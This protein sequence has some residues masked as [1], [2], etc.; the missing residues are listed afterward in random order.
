MMESGMMT[1]RL[2][3]LALNELS[4]VKDLVSLECIPSAFQDEFDRFFFGK[5]LVRKGEK[6]FAYP[7]D[8]R[9]WV[10]FVFMRYKG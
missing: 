1:D 6:L 4:N 2:N 5:T 9:R 3:L 8:I 10:D 7:N